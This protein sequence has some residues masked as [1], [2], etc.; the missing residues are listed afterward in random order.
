LGKL[1]LT[2]LKFGEK[3]I[4]FRFGRFFEKSR[5]ERKGNTSILYLIIYLFILNYTKWFLIGIRIGFDSSRKIG[6]NHFLFWN[7]LSNSLFI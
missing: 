3:N 5:S 6:D 2:I 4:F 7:L 1:T